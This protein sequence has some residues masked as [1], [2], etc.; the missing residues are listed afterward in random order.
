[1]VATAEQ[2]T[3]AAEP[4]VKAAAQLSESIAG[5]SENVA[6]MSPASER[7]DDFGAGSQEMLLEEITEEEVAAEA[8]LKQRAA[9]ESSSLAA[10]ASGQ[11]IAEASLAAQGLP[12]AAAGAGG[13]PQCIS[14]ETSIRALDKFCIWC[15]EKQ[16]DRT[17]PQMKRCAECKTQLPVTANFCFVCGNDVG[18][19]PRKRVRAPMELF[20]EED[21]ELFP[22]FET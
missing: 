12:K 9:L 15:G 8:E 17:P 5:P 20:Q 22:T 1:M 14:C 18:L 6:V 4:E 21:P 10:P 13:G 3:Q 7:E 16:P 11:S 19:H 2:S